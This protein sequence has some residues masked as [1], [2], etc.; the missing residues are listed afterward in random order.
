MYLFLP[1]KQYFFYIALKMV[2]KSENFP[3][4][5]LFYFRKDKNAVEARKKLCTVYE[6]VLSERQC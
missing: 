4:V 1:L 5:L 6:D 3:H 2:D